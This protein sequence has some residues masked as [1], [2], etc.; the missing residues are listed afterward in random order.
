MP[1]ESEVFR[2]PYYVKDFMNK[3]V[4]DMKPTKMDEPIKFEER[5]P[6][7]SIDLPNEIWIN[8]DGN[9]KLVMTKSYIT[10]KTKQLKEFGY[11]KLT[12][13]ETTEQLKKILT[14]DKT[15]TIIGQF[16]VDEIVRQ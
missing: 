9:N 7:N 10:A 5:E 15:L 3:Q 16:M 2:V 6:H 8:I 13:Q 11:N 12:E 1:R 4:K 14:K